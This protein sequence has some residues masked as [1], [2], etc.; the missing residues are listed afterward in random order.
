MPEVLLNLAIIRPVNSTLTQDLERYTRAMLMI[1]FE[2]TWNAMA[3]AFRVDEPR[4]VVIIYPG[5]GVAMQILWKPFFGWVI[6][7]ASA[8][9]SDIA[10]TILASR[11]QSLCGVR[12]D[13]RDTVIAPMRLDMSDAYGSVPSLCNF[14]KPS[15]SEK[16]VRL[17]FAMVADF[18]SEEQDHE[19]HTKWC[20]MRVVTDMSDNESNNTELEEL[21]LPTRA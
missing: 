8:S 11:I 12:V 21:V 3:D 19:R 13:L 17:H 4:K 7:V 5:S 9:L 16:E 1:F 14:T 20:W 2:A 15:G 6:L 18:E 10:F